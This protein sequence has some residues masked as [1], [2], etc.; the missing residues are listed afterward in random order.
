[1]SKYGKTPSNQLPSQ[2]RRLR[3]RERACVKGRPGTPDARLPTLAGAG[4]LRLPGASAGD[5]AYGLSEQVE[6]GADAV[7]QVGDHVH[8]R[9]RRRVDAGGRTT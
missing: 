2:R 9:T 8:R 6:I 5:P 3:P 4:C 1:M 7:G